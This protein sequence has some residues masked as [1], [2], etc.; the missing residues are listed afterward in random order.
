MVMTM[1]M[2][3]NMNMVLPAVGRNIK[4][5]KSRTDQLIKMLYLL[6]SLKHEDRS[7]NIFVKEDD[8]L[9]FHRHPVAQSTDC[10]RGKVGYERGLHLFEITWS[11]RQRGTHAVVGVST[12]N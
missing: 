11:T 4:D 3:M 5:Y 1:V 12:G 8:K 10:I 6:C 9:T 7:Y 2:N